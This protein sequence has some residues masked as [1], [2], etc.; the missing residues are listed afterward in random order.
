MNLRKNFGK[1][2]IFFAVLS[3]IWLAL[4][5]FNIVPLILMIP[6]ESLIR[7]HA[8]LPVICLLLASWA[9]WNDD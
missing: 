6:G 9:F 7:S 1:L 8:T 5:L 4:G 3:I 2:A